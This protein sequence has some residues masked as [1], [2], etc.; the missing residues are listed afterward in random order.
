MLRL[1]AGTSILGANLMTI[2]P[3]YADRV[4]HSPIN[5]YS[6]L[7]AFQGAGAVL[8]AVLLT[9]VSVRFGRGRVSSIMLMGMVFSALL[10]SRMVHIELAAIFIACAGFAQV[11]FF[12]NVN[13]MIQHEVPDEFRGRVMSLFTL[14]FLGLMPFGALV[15][16]FIAELV[17]P[18][19]ALALYALL[20]G[21]IGLAIMAR[22][23]QIW[24]ID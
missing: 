4:L 12:V 15:L 23:P 1:A 16:G 13:T 2:L 8:A 14:T 21:L 17:G 7:T 24:H 20:N 9:G 10:M 11:M 5:G 3:A 22:W 18:G 19:D 6:I